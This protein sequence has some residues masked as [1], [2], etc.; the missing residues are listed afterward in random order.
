MVRQQD[1]YRNMPN[2]FD[3]GSVF[4]NMSQV[5]GAFGM[6]WFFPIAPWRLDWVQLQREELS[7]V[8]DGR[9]NKNVID[10]AACGKFRHRA[11]AA[12]Q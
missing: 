6:D 12:M 10:P 8:V 5:F 3:Q 9:A 2:P 4:G 1:N 7:G 11:S